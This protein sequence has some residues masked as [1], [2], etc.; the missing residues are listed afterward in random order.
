MKSNFFLINLNSE[1][2]RLISV[3]DELYKVDLSDTLIRIEAC[4]KK[5]A[6]II[7]YQYISQ[8]AE[9]NIKNPISTGILPNYAAVGC[10]IS[11]IKCWKYIYDNN[12]EDGF[13]IEDDMKIQD[14]K[15][16]K[17]DLWNIQ[18][19][20]NK[21]KSKKIFI[22][23]NTKKI[24]KKYRLRRDYDYD[25]DYYHNFKIGDKHLNQITDMFCGTYFYYVNR[26]MAK[27][28]LDNLVNIDYQ[29]D[30]EIGKLSKK[31]KYDHN[32]IFL[33]YNTDS[34]IHNNNLKSTIQ[35][36]IL[37]IEDIMEIFNISEDI[38]IY[39]Y[40]YIPNCFKKTR[41]KL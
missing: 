18:R 29:I 8:K 25:Y 3:L 35:F 1:K 2:E 40:K 24:L 21:N 20:I 11:H 16:F 17:N 4:D 5:K 28:L 39:I 9:E 32:N 6:E 30:L 37:S 22:G 31:F 36:Y 15:N 12:L 33:N 13:I 41:D 38:A 7:S 26:D 23:F 10:A 14:I 27:Q 19:L 34:L